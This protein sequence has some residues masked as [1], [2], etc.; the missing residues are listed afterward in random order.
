MEMSEMNK[1]IEKIFW[2]LEK[3]SFELISLNSHFYGESLLVIGSEYV[4]K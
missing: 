4:K 1:N 3:I 2:I